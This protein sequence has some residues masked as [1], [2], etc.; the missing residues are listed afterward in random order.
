MNDPPAAADC[1]LIGNGFLGQPVNAISSLTFVLVGLLLMRRR[2]VLGWAGIAVGF[3]S[4]LFHGPMPGWGKW[5]H[6]VSLALVAVAIAFEARPRV[7]AVITGAVAAVFAIWPGVAQAVT[8]ILAI[9]SAAIVFARRSQI[10]TGPGVAAALMLV[11]GAVIAAL[12]RSGGLLC[13]PDTIVQ[14]HGVWHLLA[15]GALW[16][17]TLASERA[18]AELRPRS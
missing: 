7:V 3:G 13:D 5:A 10:R 17:W 8:A 11:A 6:D 2:P 12:S 1:E 15:A 9:E 14:G 4:F 16:L 18:P